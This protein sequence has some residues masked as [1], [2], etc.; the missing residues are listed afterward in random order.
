MLQED[1]EK[2]PV[3]SVESIGSSLKSGLTMPWLHSN[4]SKLRLA[5]K[6]ALAMSLASLWVSIPHLREYVAY[7][8]SMWVGITVA[9]ISLENTGSSVIKCIDRLWGTLVAGA[10]AL[11]VAKLLPFEIMYVGIA[12][13]A[14]FAFVAILLKNPERSYASECA[15]T[16]LAS[17]LFGSF[18]NEIDVNQYVTQRIM[19]IFIGV[20]TFLFVELAL[21]SRSSRIIVEACALKWFNDLQRYASICRTSVVF[22]VH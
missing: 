8:N 22:H 6:T 16:S 11:L 12:S 2:A 7:P 1:D 5:L 4:P 14:V 9:V 21:F 15:V 18:Y 10:Y 17:I 20:I 13:Y 3:V 19:L